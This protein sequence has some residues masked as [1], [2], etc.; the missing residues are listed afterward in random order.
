MTQ[1]Q[2]FIAQIYLKVDGS[3]VSEEIMD[4]L[5]SAEVD[6][7]LLLPDM[8]SMNLRDPS[9][10]LIDSNQFGL[11]K[12]VEISVKASGQSS[13][14]K[15]FAGEITAIEPQFWTDK[16]ATVTIRGYDQSHRLH[17]VKRTKTYVQST[18]SDIAQ[19][20]ARESGLRASVDST[21]EVHE[22]I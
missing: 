13:T 16:G 22:Y 17:R 18:D 9:F 4:G 3:S 2:D 21:R 14:S 19:T 1:S 20:I 11:G 8:F 10:T 15:L 7:S 5:I 12:P 6:D